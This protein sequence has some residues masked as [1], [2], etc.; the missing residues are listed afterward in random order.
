MGKLVSAHGGT[1]HSQIM[2]NRLEPLFSQMFKDE[3]ST[4]LLG[5]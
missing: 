1:K 3:K 5:G 4:E 2:N